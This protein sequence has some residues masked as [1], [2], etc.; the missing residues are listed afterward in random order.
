M[1]GSIKLE[2]NVQPR[3]LAASTF[4]AE[5]DPTWEQ[6]GGVLPWIFGSL[7]S[8]G[9]SHFA[10]V[11]TASPNLQRIDSKQAWSVGLSLMGSIEALDVAASLASTASQGGKHLAVIGSASAPFYPTGMQS[12]ALEAKNRLNMAPAMLSTG[13]A[14][15]WIV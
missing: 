10:L 3:A 8:V 15:Q 14:G 13:S 7:P 4:V 2:P 5:T 1:C 11:R 12:P 9:P 6:S